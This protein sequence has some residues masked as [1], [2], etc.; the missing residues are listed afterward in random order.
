LVWSDSWGNKRGFTWRVAYKMISEFGPIKLL[1]GVGA[2]GFARYGYEVYQELIKSVWGDNVLTNAHNEWVT[3]IVDG[4]ILGGA[5]YLG[6]YISEMIKGVKKAATDPIKIAVSASIASYICHNLFC[7][8]QV[9]CTPC[10]FLLMAI[11]EY[12]NRFA[13]RRDSAL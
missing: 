6:I 11:A 9:L 13:E 8:Q 2:D 10:I 5:S 1:L 3:M 7:Y 4:G 12:Q